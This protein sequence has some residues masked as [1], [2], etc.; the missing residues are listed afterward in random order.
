MI[1]NQKVPVVKMIPLISRLPRGGGRGAI[2]TRPHPTPSP[3]DLKSD[4]IKE[5]ACPIS[6]FCK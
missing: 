5:I 3:M 6:I 4:C 2:E 1:L